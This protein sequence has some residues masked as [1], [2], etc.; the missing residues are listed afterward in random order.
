MSLESITAEWDE[1]SREYNKLEVGDYFVL[2]ALTECQKK[3]FHFNWRALFSW[4]KDTSNEYH[5]MLEKL[6]QLQQKCMK[7]IAH[8]RYRISQISSNLK[9]WVIIL[10]VVFL[11]WF[12]AL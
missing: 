6:E 1:L 10:V 2:F 9:K 7:D 8:Q 12:R 5:E 4:F 11:L 3:V